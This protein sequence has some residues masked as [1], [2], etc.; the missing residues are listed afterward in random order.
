MSVDI[1]HI[2]IISPALFH[3]REIEIVYIKN[4]SN[5]TIKIHQWTILFSSICSSVHLSVYYCIIK[6]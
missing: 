5:F 4:W 6:I 1:I 3:D 2:F